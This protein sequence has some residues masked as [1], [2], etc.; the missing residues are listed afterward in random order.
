MFNY[1]V[2]LDSYISWNCI[3]TAMDDYQ[4]TLFLLYVVIYICEK[5]LISQASKSRIF[6][7][8]WIDSVEVVEKW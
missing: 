8:K 1:F 2:Y 3:D 7:K 6:V 5:S 4:G